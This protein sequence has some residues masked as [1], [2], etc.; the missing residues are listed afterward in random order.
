MPIYEKRSVIDTPAPALFAWH[1]R[2]GAFERLAPPWEHLRVVSRHGGISD[3]SRLTLE[4]RRGPIKTRWEA[5]HRDFVE[6]KQFTDVQVAGPFKRWEHTHRV[7]P[8]GDARATLID[9]VEYA[10]PLGPLGALAG[11][12]F[13]RRMM[14]RLFAFRHRR[15]ATDLGRHLAI[16]QHRR[17]RIVLTGRTGWILTQLAAFL[18]TGGHV[19]R[20][21][22]T[23]EDPRTQPSE[24]A[25]GPTLVPDFAALEQ[26]DAVIHM[27]LGDL[28]GLLSALDQRGSRARTVIALPTLALPTATS[29]SQDALDLALARATRRV[30]V[31]LTPGVLAAWPA[32]E[33][34][35]PREALAPSVDGALVGVDDLI[36]AT[37]F[38]LCDDSVRGLL[39][40]TLP[41]V[42]ATSAL[43]SA[44]ARWV[45]Q[46]RVLKLLSPEAASATPITTL[47]FTPLNPTLADTILAEIGWPG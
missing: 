32:L 24:A 33:G 9:H 13:A 26:A 37:Y 17:L 19:V 21:F 43:P 44:V 47:G 46:L 42:G 4:L 22:P 36:G 28:P 3:G 41:R 18:G 10:L 12:P 11:G 39:D 20:L 35:V 23:S 5:L 34:S 14:D 45:D 16:G 40:V 25:W 1:T 7:E 30:A 8:V 2:P 38:A 6:G 15:I 27:G 31:L 29:V